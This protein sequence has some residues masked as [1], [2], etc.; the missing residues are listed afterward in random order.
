MTQN[1]SG[2]KLQFLNVY[3]HHLFLLIVLCVVQSIFHLV[4]ELSM[5]LVLGMVGMISISS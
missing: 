3:E 4:K 2:R 5:T 1:K